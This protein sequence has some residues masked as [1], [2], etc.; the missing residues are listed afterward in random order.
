MNKEKFED[1]LFIKAA[2]TTPGPS[3]LRNQGK[4]TSNT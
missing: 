4:G 3:A 2:E 1:L